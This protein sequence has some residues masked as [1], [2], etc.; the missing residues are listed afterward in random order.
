MSWGHSN[1]EI[2]GQGLGRRGWGEKEIVWVEKR[3][4]LG[5]GETKEEEKEKAVVTV[6]AGIEG[7]PW[8]RSRKRDWSDITWVILVWAWRQK[9]CV[10]NQRHWVWKTWVSERGLNCIMG[11][12][13]GL[14]V[15]TSWPPLLQSWLSPILCTH[16]I[17]NLS[18][19]E[20]ITVGLQQTIGLV[21]N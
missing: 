6:D 21:I 18:F 17:I 16:V 1:R 5:K 14:I 11:R 8:G 4:G 20:W 12:A 2:T 19:F 3:V 7:K 13:Y 10:T 9:T 15:R